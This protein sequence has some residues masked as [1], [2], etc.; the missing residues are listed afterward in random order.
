MKPKLKTNLDCAKLLVKYLACEKTEH[1]FVV[2]LCYFVKRLFDN[3]YISLGQIRRLKRFIDNQI[4]DDPRYEP[5]KF[6]WGD[7]TVRIKW[8]KGYIKR[9]QREEQK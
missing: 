9:Q 5:Y 3:Y 6:Q 8:L 2:G 1:L 4:P 7:R